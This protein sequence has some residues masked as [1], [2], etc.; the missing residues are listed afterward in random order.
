[1]RTAVSCMSLSCVCLALAACASGPTTF[2]KAD[3][4]LSQRDAD[5]GA[6][7]NYVLNTP[8]GRKEVENLKLARFIGGG[9]ISLAVQSAEN[10]DTKDDPKKDSNNKLTHQACMQQKGYKAQ[11]G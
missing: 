10:S 5:D 3:V 8:E 1:M 11:L 4:S 7:W 2:T 6:C 9:V